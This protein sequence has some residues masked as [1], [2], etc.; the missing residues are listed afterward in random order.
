VGEYLG[1]HWNL[2]AEVQSAIA[3]HHDFDEAEVSDDTGLTR[4]LPALVGLSD[5]MARM[6]GKGRWIADVSL[7]DLPACQELGIE[8][9]PSTLEFLDSIPDLVE[10]K[11]EA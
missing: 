5:T 4:M 6:L 11:A 3:H 7:F 8:R 1:R 2:D 10:E 9:N